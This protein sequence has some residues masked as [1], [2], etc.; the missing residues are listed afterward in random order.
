MQ[1]PLLAGQRERQAQRAPEQQQHH[2]ASAVPP[3]GTRTRFAN[4]SRGNF[5]SLSQEAERDSTQYDYME[6]E[7]D[8]SE[9][10]PGGPVVEAIRSLGQRAW[11]MKWLLPG[12]GC[13]LALLF[14][15]IA[16]HAAT[17]SY[18]SAMMDSQRRSI[19]TSVLDLLQP[20]DRLAAA[21][22]GSFAEGFLVTAVEGASVTVVLT[23]FFWVIRSQNLRLW[24][25][26]M[27][28]LTIVF[29]YKGFVAWVT[30]VPYPTGWKGCTEALN[31]A[32]KEHY[33]YSSG[34]A[35]VFG[36]IVD[37]AAL[38]LLSLVS[39]LR[40]D[41][42]LVCVRGTS[43]GS[44]L[45]AVAALGL[46]EATRVHS[47]RVRS[48]YRAVYHLVSAVILTLIVVLDSM[49]S[50]SKDNQYSVDVVVALILAVL[51]H[52]SPV[53][54]ISTDRWLILGC[55][56]AEEIKDGADVGDLVIAP[57]CFPLCWSQ[58]RY[59]LFKSPAM[60]AEKQRQRQEAER[61]MQE[62]AVRVA[63]EY[64]SE[65]SAAARRIVD[66][67]AELEIVAQRA[68]LRAK[69]QAT[70]SK[71]R[72]KQALTAAEVACRQKVSQAE[73]QF[74]ARALM[75]RDA[76][77]NKAKTMAQEAAARIPEQEKPEDSQPPTNGH[78]APSAAEAADDA[79]QSDGGDAAAKGGE[80]S[81]ITAKT[82]EVEAEQAFEQKPSVGTW[83]QSRMD[84]EEVTLP[85][86]LQRPEPAAWFLMPSIGTWL[87][88][89]RQQP[90][91][92]TKLSTKAD[93]QS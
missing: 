9:R 15:C 81:G 70:E 72:I 57:C 27:I 33:M 32:V 26:S 79:K 68:A 24:T 1:G 7:H 13:L 93:G 60:L 78:D 76:A 21:L 80:T 61:R 3:A 92:Q 77:T 74:E 59:Y 35:A 58:G 69:E 71:E 53:I 23:W 52:S 17:H 39:L 38:W 28:V 42:E 54:A 18:I 34:V 62:E 6:L 91:A 2:E 29:M 84:A 86:S 56:G 10:R 37:V 43:G 50:L 12:I 47:R 44:C 65:Q 41:Q 8:P 87:Q 30:V 20:P 46:F 82:A 11:L 31:G 25:R 4:D 48:V 5:G 36:S 49:I 67:E 88:R 45:L 85:K 75:E 22:K 16:L 63:E 64:Q 40:S 55:P 14:Q 51:L 89:R 90:S 19:S 66:L 83:V 73:L